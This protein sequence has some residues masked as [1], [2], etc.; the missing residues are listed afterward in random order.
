MA[1]TIENIA[2]LSSPAKSY[3][4]NVKIVKAPGV[5]DTTALQFRCK[6][7]SIPES[8][9]E[10]TEINYRWMKIAVPGRDASGHT[11]DLSFWDSVDLP[12]YTALYTWRQSLADY[13]TGY[14][15]AKADLVGQVTIE[16][17]DGLEGVIGTFNL[18]NA[19]IENL[20]AI[21]L[22]YSSSDVLNFSVTMRYDWVTFGQSS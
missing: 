14:Q 10:M 11:I 2:K 6:S 1:T 18:Y 4:F 7:A 20:Q 12:V 9:T 15:Q 22:D 8:S 19:M 17:L 3:D 13:T 21:T 16:L 5:T